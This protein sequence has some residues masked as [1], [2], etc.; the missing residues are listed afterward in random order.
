MVVGLKMKE[1]KK[2][3]KD[4]VASLMGL[5]ECCLVVASYLSLSIR[6]PCLVFVNLSACVL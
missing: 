1:R 4:W 3:E 5:G 6:N 2:V